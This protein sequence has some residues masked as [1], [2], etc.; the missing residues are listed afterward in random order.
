[1][2]FQTIVTDAPFAAI[3]PWISTEGPN[4]TTAVERS[5]RDSGY[6]GL[7][8]VQVFAIPCGVQLRGTVPTHHL[9]QLAQTAA[10][11]VPGVCAIRNELDVIS[12]R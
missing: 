5:L 3:N 4:V 2:N 8:N 6:R 10:L 1:M 11:R 9:K 12:A 7:R